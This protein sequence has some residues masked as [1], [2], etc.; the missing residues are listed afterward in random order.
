MH[1]G[2]TFASRFPRSSNPFVV[3]EWGEGGNEQALA[4]HFCR[5]RARTQ[6]RRCGGKNQE[7]MKYEIRL[8]HEKGGDLT[9]GNYK[10]NELLPLEKDPIK[11][12]SKRRN[13]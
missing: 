13:P 1:S 3:K 6:E 8:K 5:T 9:G 4:E 2:I 10:D 12:T 7:S 11:L